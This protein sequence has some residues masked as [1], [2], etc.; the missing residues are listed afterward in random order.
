MEWVIKVNKRI[1]NGKVRTSTSNMAKTLIYFDD[2]LRTFVKATSVRLLMGV[3]YMVVPMVACVSVHGR[4]VSLPRRGQADQRPRTPPGGVAPQAP[5]GALP[6]VSLSATKGLCPTP[7]LRLDKRKLPWRS[8][9]SGLST[10]CP[11]DATCGK[12]AA[13]LPTK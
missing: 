10:C 7:T 5:C 11:C 6:A 13:L 9:H 4:T 8:G 3:Q 1:L 12:T 2:A